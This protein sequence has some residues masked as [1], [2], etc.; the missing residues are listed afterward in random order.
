M[1]KAL[2]IIWG[3]LH[4]SEYSLSEDDREDV[5]QDVT[6][7]LIEKAHTYT[8]KNASSF[9]TWAATVYSNIIKD[10]AKRTKRR[11][12][13][14]EFAELIELQH[15]ER[16]DSSEVEECVEAILA[17]TANNK[18]ECTDVVVSLWDGLRN[19]FDQKEIA[20]QLGVA[21]NTFNQKIRRCRKFLLKHKDDFFL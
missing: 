12:P 10:E 1:Q 18:K 2:N 6:S 8:G 13:P 11:M 19:G 9:S 16:P 14:K 4:R 7:R 17:F 20:K 21:P 15:A 5:F 3:K